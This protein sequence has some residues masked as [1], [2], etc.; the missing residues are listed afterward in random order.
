MST[1]HRAAATLAVAAALALPAL[2]LGEG[3]KVEESTI[4]GMQKAIQDGT[5]TCRGVV[6]AYLD[7]V[8]AYNGSCTALVT[9]DGKPIA[10]VKGRVLGGKAVAYPTK[11]VAASS[12]LP[13]LSEYKG[14][15]IEYGRMEPTVSDP[16]VQQ[17]WGMRVGMANAGQ[18][19]ALETLNIRG[20]RSVTCKGKF[21]A[22]VSSGPLPKDAP[23]ACEEFRKQP[24]ALEYAAQLDEQYGT[25][26]D[27]K[28]MPM[29]CVVFAWKNW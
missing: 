29:Y 21:D 15:P 20:E 2:A 17:Q 1:L 19:N 12:F 6:Q 26:P 3:F 18:V 22:P 23:A 28:K 10:P 4:D 11:T 24:D 14:P 8:K 16:R 5:I 27:L 25:K 9:A 13:N 7:R